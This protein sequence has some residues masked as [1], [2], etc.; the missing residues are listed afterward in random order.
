[1]TRPATPNASALRWARAAA[2]LYAAWGLF[3][4]KVAWNIAELG[5]IES[6]LAQ[7]RL[8]QLAA[9]MATIALFAIGVGVFLNARN[10]RVGYWLNLC[11]TGWAD[12]IWVAVVVL[13]GY[14]SPVRGFVPPAIFVAAAICS[15][16]ARRGAR[17]AM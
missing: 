4:L 5:R 7:G 9:Y 11:V 10:D 12:A 14:V 16:L 8:F 6:G 17:I 13:P 2:V 1:M 3:H 15:T